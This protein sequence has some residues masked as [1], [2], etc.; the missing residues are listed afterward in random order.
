V[1]SKLDADG[2]IKI[3]IDTRTEAGTKALFGG[4]NPAAVLYA[5]N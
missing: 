2:D 5:K 1:I 3:L 4:T